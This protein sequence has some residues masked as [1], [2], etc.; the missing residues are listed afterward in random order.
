MSKHR[1]KYSPEMPWT[2]ERQLKAYA[3]AEGR[4]E[5]HK[6]LNLSWEQNRRWF[7]QILEY[8]LASFPAYSQHN[9]THCHAVIHNI[10]CLLGEDEIRRLSPTDC[11][12]ILMAVYLHDVGMC[13]TDEDR[14]K[15]VG[16]NEFADWIDKLEKSTDIDYSYAIKA[17]KR[18]DYEFK[19]TDDAVKNKKKNKILYNQKMDVFYALTFLIS[20]QQRKNHA[21]VASERM[22]DWVTEP[23][24]MQSGLSMTG[25]PTRIFLLIAECARLHGE[26][27]LEDLMSLLLQL[28]ENDNGFAQDMYH[29]RFAAVLLLIGDALD[30]DN[31][32][33]HPFA[34]LYAGR[35]FN[36]K[37]QM[38]YR[39]HQA[40]RAL[41]ITS[42]K[43]YI[44]VDCENPSEM[45]QLRSEVIWLQQFI[46]ECSYQWSKIAPDNYC[47]CLPVVEF[48]R[49]S[50]GGKVIDEKLVKAQFNLSQEK[51]FRL[52]EGASLYENNYVY[53]REMVQNGIDAVKFQ[54]WNDLD[55][56]E[57]DTTGEVGLY[58]ANNEHPLRKYPVKIDFAVRKRF[59]RTPEKLEPI[60]ADDLKL[61]D[62]ALEEY[63][64][65]VEVSVQ[66]CGIG[67]GAEDICAISKVGTSQDYRQNMIDQMPLWLHP[68][69]KF[70]IGLQSLFQADD[71][72]RCVTRTHRDECYEIVFHSG[73]N[74][75]GYI[76]VVPKDWQDGERGSVP[77]GTKFTL[78]VPVSRK[79]P[80]SRNMSGWAGMD[81]YNKDY[82]R[83]S[84]LRRSFEL[85]KQMEE[86]LNSWIGE[87]LF[88]LTVREEE[89]H[90][91]V[92]G[93][94][95]KKL[96]PMRPSRKWKVQW[97]KISADAKKEVIKRINEGRY[98]WLFEKHDE[99][100]RF[101][102]L[103]G[104]LEE[105][106]SAYYLD[107]EDCKLYIWSQ[108]AKCFFGCGPER[109]IQ[110]TTKN[111]IVRTGN[112]NRRKKET[113]DEYGNRIQL[114][115]KG[116]FVTDIT[117]KE[118]EL[119]EFIDIKNDSLQNY[120]YMNRNMLS[121]EGE[122]YIRNEII[123]QLRKTFRLVL[124]EINRK[125]FTRIEENRDWLKREICTQYETIFREFGKTDNIQLDHLLKQLNSLDVLDFTLIENDIDWA[126]ETKTEKKN[127]FGR[128]FYIKDEPGCHKLAECAGK[129][130]F[131]GIM[132]N[133]KSAN[134]GKSMNNGEINIRE[135][136]SERMKVNLQ[137]KIKERKENNL[138]IFSYLLNHLVEQMRYID[139]L[140]YAG[141]EEE[142]LLEFTRSIKKLQE[143]V[144]LY[145]MFF[146]YMNREGTAQ[147]SNC[148]AVLDQPC[149]WEYLNT[150]IANTLKYV[151]NI[152]RKSDETQ[153][154]YRRECRKIYSSVLFIP[155]CEENKS[156][157]L[158]ESGY[159][160]AEIMCNNCHFAVFSTRF[161]QYDPWKH[162]LIKL[163]PLPCMAPS[164]NADGESVLDVLKRK[165]NNQVECRRRWAFLDQW[166]KDT[167]DKIIRQWHTDKNYT[168]P[169]GEERSI[170]S[171]VNE[172]IWGNE[173]TRW[174]VR[175]LP[176]ISVGSDQSGDNRLN[177]L[178]CRA[179]THVFFDARILVLLVRRMEEQYNAYHIPRFSTTV[180]DGM[181]ALLCRNISSDIIPV[182]RGIVPEGNRKNQM[183]LAI[184]SELPT[185]S[186]MPAKD[187]LEKSTRKMEIKTVYKLLEE[188]RRSYED[189]EKAP[190]FAFFPAKKI[191][192]E[193]AYILKLI[194]FSDDFKSIDL[195]IV[196]CISDCRRLHLD[197]TI[198]ISLMSRNAENL[199]A[200][201]LNAYW[202]FLIDQPGGCDD[203]AWSKYNEVDVRIDRQ[204]YINSFLL[205][206]YG[207]DLKSLP[208]EFSGIQRFKDIEEMSRITSKVRLAF[209]YYYKA[210]L[211]DYRDTFLQC[212]CKWYH[213]EIWERDPGKNYFL[214]Y[215]QQVCMENTEQELEKLYMAQIRRLLCAEI[216]DVMPLFFKQSA[217][218][219]DIKRMLENLTRNYHKKS[220]T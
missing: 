11:F 84:M 204:K 219:G 65:G 123:P 101:K 131:N 56:T 194:P 62:D 59:R 193:C 119:I 104:T 86:Y 76:N 132:N 209:E 179:E 191:I 24:K 190:D 107:V 118:N 114:F 36:E 83:C 71:M 198:D 160:F 25:I 105:D 167:I 7:A 214:E 215:S 162:L 82:R 55:A 29:P 27:E 88:P 161:S 113:L 67:I 19:E 98:C 199:Q 77:Y 145:G 90:S 174:I 81:P 127:R 166:N 135:N 45:R 210:A 15:I 115:L 57:Y 33:F 217:Y 176:S 102:F 156:S 3:E 40:I 72:F 181:D 13:I 6:I 150:R 144:I 52:L 96:E 154:E 35:L 21:S 207:F 213:D 75:E 175:K 188:F 4:T 32:R 158:D 143:Y 9:E 92:V 195:E 108:S 163:S 93:E 14:E 42:K 128:I 216:I 79:E 197:N 53:L 171:G 22:K 109:I 168:N 43:I 178:I 85:M 121:A 189:P 196:K 122:D 17:L 211:T 99:K 34:K 87:C 183:L 54:Y 148:A 39:K 111:D 110:A 30:I 60:T 91:S 112:K 187:E 133:E 12:T 103:Y 153:Y 64:F 48:E 152:Y 78:F 177:V 46:K 130:D 218:L 37:S 134:D 31:H 220:S 68:T 18:T 170:S 49:I 155:A 164:V 173:M 165:P 159:S 61:A 151:Y 89:L 146:F 20:E 80:H 184:G 180:W 116:L 206:S 185:E 44:R 63:E 125:A 28:P 10:E 5:R 142:N 169:A 139:K 212:A 201:I 70:G 97:Q 141:P 50:L 208:E 136:C 66:D 94:W 120:L 126:V 51:A 140:L 202:S 16:S 73:T 8:T 117:Y 172:A 100:D 23:E 182:R 200:T 2:I 38:H 74:N 186:I 147:K 137:N 26:I 41:Q 192:E 205:I 106:E 58:A 69:G 124:K 138:D 1:N 203:K 95:A 129:A 47:G 149:G 157:T